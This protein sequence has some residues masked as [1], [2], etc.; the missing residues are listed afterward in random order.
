M[1][2]RIICPE[3]DY[4]ANLQ[5]AEALHERNTPRE[6]LP[7]VTM[8]YGKATNMSRATIY[9]AR[10]LFH[11]TLH[12]PVCALWVGDPVDTLVATEPRHLAFRVG[13]NIADEVIDHLL[14][15]H[16]PFEEPRDMPILETEPLEAFPGNVLS[17]VE[18]AY[19]GDHSSPKP[20]H[21]AR[22]D[23][24]VE[25]WCWPLYPDDEYVGVYGVEGERGNGPAS[26]D[27][28]ERT[29]EPSRI[30]F[31]DAACSLRVLL[32]EEDKELLDRFPFEFLAEG[33]VRFHIWND[34][35]IDD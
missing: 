24:F 13:N 14:A 17:V 18:S 9:V 1:R 12:K 31:I 4:R 5:S 27:Y 11:E 19:L 3:R 33:A 16:L 26:S 6:F 7:K 2:S 23:E 25:T 28:L 21:E 20:A 15:C 34:E 29:D 35:P 22:S 30:V 8:R 10:F 32:R